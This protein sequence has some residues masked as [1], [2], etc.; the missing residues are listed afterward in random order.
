MGVGRMEVLRVDFDR[1][2]EIEF[3]GAH[4]TSDTLQV[5]SIK[6]GANVVQYARALASRWRNYWSE[7]VCS[8]PSCGEFAD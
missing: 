5:R 4:V 3:R 2:V 7:G 1:S 6:I 8:R